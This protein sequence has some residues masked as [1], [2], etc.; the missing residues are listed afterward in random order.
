MSCTSDS[1]AAS[2]GP[3]FGTTVRTAVSPASLKEAGVTAAALPSPVILSPTV[4]AAASGSA[5]SRAS[6]AI[7]N[8]PLKPAPKESD[9]MS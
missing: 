8:G 1:V 6:T 3:V 5:A 4:S 7:M 2:L 9:S